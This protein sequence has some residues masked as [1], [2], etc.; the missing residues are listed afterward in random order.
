MD[1]IMTQINAVLAESEANGQCRDLQIE[2]QWLCD[3]GHALGVSVRVRVETR[4][5]GRIMVHFV[6]RLLKFRHAVDPKADSPAE[7]EVDCE[8]EGTTYDI[9][10][11]VPGCNAVRTWHMGEAALERFLSARKG[12]K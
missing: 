3:R 1:G 2:K 12:E 5:Q 8:I 10:C 7:V 11:D 9:H 6:D 4:I